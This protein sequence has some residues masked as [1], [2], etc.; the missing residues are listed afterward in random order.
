MRQ[1][2]SDYLGEVMAFDAG[3]G[4]IIEMLKDRGE[5]NN[6]LI[7]VS[8]DHGMPG[9]THGKCNLYD[10]GTNVTLAARWPSVIKP[11]RVVDDMVSLMD[12]APTFLD[13]IGLR[14]DV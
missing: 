13:G 9:F 8:G 10:F 11:G 1:D 7:V 12:L 6:T 14:N 4:V 2:F 5:L 3:L